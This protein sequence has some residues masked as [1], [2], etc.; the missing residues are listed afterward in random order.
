[1]EDVL[2]FH[3]LFCCQYQGLNDAGPEAPAVGY[4]HHRKN[5]DEVD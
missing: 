4:P 3:I 5:C 1:M 2:M